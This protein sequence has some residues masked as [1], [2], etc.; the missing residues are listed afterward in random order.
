MVRQ[1]LGACL[2]DYLAHQAVEVRRLTT[3]APGGP[4]GGEDLHDLRVALRR[5]QSTLATGAAAYGKRAA[6]PVRQEARALRRALGG[7]RDVE[8]VGDVLLP[9]IDDPSDRALVRSVL[10]GRRERARTAAVAAGGRTEALLHALGRLVADPPTTA[11]AD[12]PARDEVPRLARREVRRVARLVERAGRRTTDA[13]RWAALHEVRK[14]AKRLRYLLEAAEQLDGLGAS[15]AIGALKQL[16][17]VLGDQHDLVVA[18]GLARDLGA[19]EPAGSLVRL[20]A[21]LES[22]AE[23][24]MPAYLDAWEAVRRSAVSSGWGR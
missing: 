10:A 15:A 13:D 19:A 1:S 22:E 5:I 16:Q 24:A 7:P 18:A 23:D 9:R 17:D 20:A 8:V 11:H 6:R 4:V 14:A 3:D 2:H 12:R 21:D